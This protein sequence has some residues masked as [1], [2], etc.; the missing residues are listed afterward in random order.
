MCSGWE[1]WIL[2]EST[3]GSL[4]VIQETE[5]LGDKITK[6]I[7]VVFMDAANKIRH[8]RD[9][10]GSSPTVPPPTGPVLFKGTAKSNFTAMVYSSRP[11]LLKANST[12]RNLTDSNTHI[13]FS[14]VRSVN[15]K[16]S[17]KF[18]GDNI[19]FLNFYYLNTSSWSLES[20]ELVLSDN[21][22]TNLTT[23]RQI[24]ATRGF[25]YHCS[26]PTEF[27]DANGS[28]SLIVYDLQTQ[29]GHSLRR[30]GDAYDCVPFVTAPIWSGL[31]VTFMLGIGLAIALSALGNIKTMTRYDSQKKGQLS[32]TVFE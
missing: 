3:N 6:N 31:M 25:S 21:T 4:S 24:V 20:V 14:V 27:R 30:F 32:I 1:W 23:Q 7:L 11:L 28:V 18:T 10:T 13:T 19:F 9:A 15:V 8:K 22:K 2:G 5:L 12:E 26:G 17:V 29:I 16:L